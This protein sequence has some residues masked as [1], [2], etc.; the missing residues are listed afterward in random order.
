MNFDKY[1][2]A[3]DK[4]DIS[5][6]SDDEIYKMFE[7]KQFNKENH[8]MKNK[9]FKKAMR[10][11]AIAAGVVVISGA[12]VFAHG[13]ISKY[14]HYNQ[15]RNRYLD[16]HE[17]INSAAGTTQEINTTAESNNLK[18]TVL[19]IK[20]DSLG[21]Y[22]TVQ[23]ETLD[24]TPVIKS[25]EF[26]VA[27]EGPAAF[28]SA[29]LTDGTHIYKLSSCNKTDESQPS[30]TATFEL[31]HCFNNLIWYEGDFIDV[32]ALN[33]GNVSLVL[34]GLYYY[35]NNIENI[36]FT[37]N[38]LKDLQNAVASS[39]KPISFSQKYPNISISN[40]STGNHEKYDYPCIFVTYNYQT[41]EDLETIKST[42]HLFNNTTGEIIFPSREYGTGDTY[43][44]VPVS[45]SDGEITLCYYQ[46]GDHEL[47][48]DMSIYK[49]IG[50]FNVTT[51]KESGK[52]SFDI[53]T[54]F[55]KHHEYTP[56]S[57]ITLLN[58]ENRID[59]IIISDS[60][61]LAE[62]TGTNQ[63]SG[64]SLDKGEPRL[65]FT[66]A[67]SDGSTYEIGTSYGGNYNID[68]KKVFIN[69][70]LRQLIDSNEVI[71]IYINDETGNTNYVELNK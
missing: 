64:F 63:S 9:I 14:I 60:T 53:S 46:P 49:I 22:A 36:N 31:S 25:T 50:D 67:F 1:K 8:S 65:L 6:I 4:I 2:N 10:F 61:F 18:V 20:G 56:D 55:S 33:N 17:Y 23:V 28:E 19:N 16:P 39:D 26:N 42:L 58:G 52:W 57:T 44:V 7:K 69:S 68:T 54:N 3:I 48:K 59:K 34:N 40:I 32:D 27:Q 21:I 71:G 66:L 30:N 70:S 51:T 15:S 29:Y 43:A 41:E 38:N 47:G 35:V 62:F 11:A 37:Y 12:S 13:E 5:T 45:E 24:N